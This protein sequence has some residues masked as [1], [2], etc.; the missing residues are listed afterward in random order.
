MLYPGVKFKIRDRKKELKRG[1]PLQPSKFGDQSILRAVDFRL[2]ERII[3]GVRR[4][5]GSDIMTLL[6]AA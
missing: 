5:A 6:R 4:G 2:E 3:S 1:L